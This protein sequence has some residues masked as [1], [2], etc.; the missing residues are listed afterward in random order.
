VKYIPSIILLLFGT[1][2]SGEDV[3]MQCEWDYSTYHFKYSDNLFK[4]K[5]YIRVNGEW[6][7]YCEGMMSSVQQ[8]YM[9]LNRKIVN[10]TVKDKGATCTFYGQDNKYNQDREAYLMWTLDFE[11]MA[12]K[13]GYST[14]NIEDGKWEKFTWFNEWQCTTF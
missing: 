14:K 10:Y 5:A 1:V 13:T 4:D 9:H 3:K 2:V 7:D 6:I 8:N 12:A 11:I